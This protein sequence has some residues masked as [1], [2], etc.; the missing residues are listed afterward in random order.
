MGVDDRSITY[1]FQVIDNVSPTAERVAGAQEKVAV[2]TENAKTAVD[3]QNISFMTQVIAVR[4]LYAGLRQV[5]SGMKELGLVDAKT[6]ESLNKVVAA[7]GMVSGTFMM[8]KGAIQIVQFLRSSEIAL[9]V[10]KTFNKV[11]DNPAQAVLVGVAG[12]AAG[13]AGG[14]L[15]GQSMGGG[16]G[17]GANV[18]QNI[19]FT[20]PTDAIQARG[21][22]VSM[23]EIAGG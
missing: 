14:Y 22:Q 1:T 21:Y 11:L 23:L 15:L 4:S 17:G 8:L 16:G 10:A 12:A 6:A 20:Q 19:T 3:S 13:A 7:V 2:S 5:T 9:A 18:T